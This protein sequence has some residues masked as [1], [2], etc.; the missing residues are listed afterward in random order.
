M[1]IVPFN[2]SQYDSLAQVLMAA[3]GGYVFDEDNLRFRDK[4]LGTAYVSKRWTALIDGTCVGFGECSQTPEMN[5]PGV[6]LVNIT[7]HPA[8]QK[9][10]IGSRL[11]TCVCTEMTAHQPRKLRTSCRADN[12]RSVAFLVNRG[13]TSSMSIKELKL[14]LTSSRARPLIPMD[15]IHGI[16]IE[17]MDSLESDPNRNRRIYTLINEIRSDMPTPQL[18]NAVPFDEFLTSFLLAPSRLPDAAFVGSQ[19]R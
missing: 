4:S 7:V 15:D 12:N 6:F 5:D 17:T 3:Y 18:V 9:C 13:F 1:E 16:T 8:N 14:N 10:G 11:Y 2:S 19:Y